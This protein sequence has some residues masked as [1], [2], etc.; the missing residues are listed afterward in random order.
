M[1]T[2]PAFLPDGKLPE[3]AS[4]LLQ[5]H[6]SDAFATFLIDALASQTGRANPFTTL[7]TTSG[8]VSN[9]RLAAKGV[10][11]MRTDHCCDPFQDLE[12][13]GG[14]NAPH[15]FSRDNDPIL[16]ALSAAGTRQ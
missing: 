2:T 14:R 4:S 11:T 9:T 13:L 8:F 6:G 10:T 12:I 5:A 7:T 15:G 1:S 16:K 3:L